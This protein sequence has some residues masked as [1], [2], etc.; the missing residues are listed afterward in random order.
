MLVDR[1]YTRDKH[2]GAP[3]FH[4]VAAPT[5]AHLEKLA[6]RIS[7]RACKMLRR[8]G[9]LGEASHDSNQAEQIDGA[10]E[11]CRKVALSRGRF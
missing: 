4:F 5:K 9:L 8:R 10:L 6:T 2:G 11:A 1:V 7:E 3:V